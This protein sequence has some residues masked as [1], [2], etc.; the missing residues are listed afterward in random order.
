MDMV[1]EIRLRSSRARVLTGSEIAGWPVRLHLGRMGEEIGAHNA[2]AAIIARIRD[3]CVL[4]LNA[5]L[6]W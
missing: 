3:S 5:R 6:P 1:P 4:E 2:C